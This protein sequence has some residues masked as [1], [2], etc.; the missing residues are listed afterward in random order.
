MNDDL[1]EELDTLLAE[2]LPDGSEFK[3]SSNR[4]VSEER[5]ADLI[6]LLHYAAEQL[7]KSPSY[8]EFNSLDLATSAD[9]IRYVFGSWNAAKEAAGLETRD[10]GGPRIQI[11]ES[12]FADISTPEKA[13]WFGALV[14][15]SS[16]QFHGENQK[17][18]LLIGRTGEKSYFVTEFAKAVDSEYSISRNTHSQTGNILTSTQISNPTFISHLRDAGY[19]YP[20]YDAGDFPHVGDGLE[21]HFLRGWLESSGYFSTGGFNISVSNV[22]RAE[23]IQGWM[24][25]CG[26]KRPTLTEK[27][28]GKAVVRVSN[29]FDVRAVFESLWPELT[30]TTPTFKPYPE[31][32]LNYLQNEYPYPENVSYLST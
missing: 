15:H 16:L 32:V 31:K 19:P 25:D 17:P 4:V 12:Y 24:S 8:K 30:E 9:A 14:A 13:Y 23:T 27:E 2:E 10:V 18:A 5:R 7:G 26:V 21:T 6:Q 22:D 20:D 1:M 3:D 28:T 11:D 29:P